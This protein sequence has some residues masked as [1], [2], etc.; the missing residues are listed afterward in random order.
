[1]S[2][3]SHLWIVLRFAIFLEV[4][5]EAGLFGL[6]WGLAITTQGY[7]QLLLHS[8]SLNH[9]FSQLLLLLGV[10]QEPLP[11]EKMECTGSL[12]SPFPFP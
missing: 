1:M 11:P 9:C 3:S 10:C 8:S 2:P 4:G 12:L 7:P 5:V 6:S